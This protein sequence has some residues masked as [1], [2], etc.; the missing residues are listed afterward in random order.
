MLCPTFVLL[1]CGQD[2]YSQYLKISNKMY[3]NHQRNVSLCVFCVRDYVV[4]AEVP[5]GEAADRQGQKSWSLSSVTDSSRA[6]VGTT[7]YK[8][9][10]LS[11]FPPRVDT[12]K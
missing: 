11:H 9:Q 8:Q 2:K 12:G 5:P 4:S 6:C 1:H 7:I 3:V 10:H